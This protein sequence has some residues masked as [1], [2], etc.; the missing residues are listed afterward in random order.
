MIPL[1]FEMARGSGKKK[2]AAAAGGVDKE[3]ECS[4]NSSDRGDDAKAAEKTVP[5]SDAKL[6]APDPAAAGGGVAHWTKFRILS[7]KKMADMLLE[8]DFVEGASKWMVGNGLTDVGKLAR[9][10]DNE[11]E[12]YAYVFRR[13]KGGKPDNMEAVKLL[14]LTCFGARAKKLISHKVFVGLIEEYW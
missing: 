4:D 9:Q 12:Q 11:I 6:N 3:A 5:P 1:V 10:T 2:A 13:G 8:L 14:K 7:K